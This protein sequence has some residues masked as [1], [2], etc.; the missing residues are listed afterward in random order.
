[1]NRIRLY[2]FLMILLAIMP[3][4]SQNLKTY[5]VQRGETIDW[6]AEKFN[7]SAE[8]L[9]AVN[10]GLESFYTGLQI[11]IPLQESQSHH[12][13]AGMSESDTQF[14]ENLCKYMSDCDMADSMFEAK[15][16]KKAQKQYK[17]VIEKYRN[18]LPC[19]D[20]VYAYALCSYNRK[21]W[22]SAIEDLSAVVIN[23]ICSEAQREHCKE[24][25]EK[26]REYREQQ[27][28]KRS[29]IIGNIFMA[30]ASVSA[31]VLSAYNNK[32]WNSAPT[33]S[34][35][36]S[37][38]SMSNS[39]YSSYV[40]TSLNN[41]ARNSILQVQQQWKQEEQQVKNNYIAI[42]RQING[43]DPNEQEI[44]AAYDSFVQI[45][46]NAYRSTLE[47]S[48][49]EDGNNGNDKKQDTSKD[50]TK[51]ILG[52]QCTVCRDTGICST[53]NGS[54][55]QDGFADIHDHYGAGINKIPCANCSDSR[56]KGNG[57]C[58]FCKKK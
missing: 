6:I 20:A 16:Y 51:K 52:Y 13:S 54:G 23:E 25:L 49:F 35:G 58:R 10:I 55:W 44:Q 31:N 11:N 50:N 30:A 53:C 28:E 27:L 47:A 19:E 1:M 3:V 8:E 5:V 43:R 46:V 48:S 14:M 38:G 12:V 37:I 32:N 45:K 56:S 41:I 29:N 33:M 9:K 22:K 42:Y 36:Q 15:E 24:L 40:N 57:V 21:K 2:I 39:Q 4:K 18:V 17:Y 26:A 34:S 7:V